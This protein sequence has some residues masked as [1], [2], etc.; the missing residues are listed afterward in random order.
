ME[1]GEVIVLLK[2]DRSF[3]S[4]QLCPFPELLQEAVASVSNGWY[5]MECHEWSTMTPLNPLTPSLNELL[6]R[7]N[8]LFDDQFNA[9]RVHPYL[10]VTT[11]DSYDSDSVVTI[12]MGEPYTF[13]IRDKR[14]GNR[15]VDIPIV[16]GTLYHMG[17][18]FP[19]EFFM[20]IQPPRE[21]ER[22]KHLSFTFLRYVH[23]KNERK[24]KFLPL[25]QT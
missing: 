21:R 15:V 8:T 18:E 5:G 10:C 20:E 25:L 1:E 16:P 14:N 9:M 22:D 11:D 7:I 2:T 12:S 6:Q 23:E 13:R 19:K 4:T 3:L 17:G 24:N